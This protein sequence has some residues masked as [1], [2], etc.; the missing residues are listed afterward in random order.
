MTSDRPSSAS[1]S[2]LGGSTPRRWLLRRRTRAAA[3]C[4]LGV[5]RDR[6]TCSG[7]GMTYD[8]ETLLMLSEDGRLWP[9]DGFSEP[10]AYVRCE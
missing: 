6:L 7:E 3:A 2:A 9:F 4:G 8:E 10:Y 5:P 1:V